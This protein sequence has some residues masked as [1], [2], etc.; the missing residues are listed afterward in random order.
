[1]TA[2]K[3]GP[4]LSPVQESDLRREQNLTA[5]ADAEQAVEVIEAKIAGMQETLQTRRD[6]V[7]QLRGELEG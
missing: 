2:V 4:E 1:M 7:V 6:E 5:L 3:T